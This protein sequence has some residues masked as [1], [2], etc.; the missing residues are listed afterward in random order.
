MCSEAKA[1]F[2]SRWPDRGLAGRRHPSCALPRSASLQPRP[3]LSHLAQAAAALQAGEADKALALL[4][5][6]PPSGPTRSPG[7]KSSLPRALSRW[8][9]STPPPAHANRQ[10]ASM[11]KTPTI[12]SGSAA[13]SAK[14]RHAPRS[15]PPLAW[16][17]APAPNSKKPFG[18]IR[19]TCRPSPLGEFYR[20]APGIVGGGVDKAQQIAAPTGQRSTPP[21]L[22]SFA[23]TSP[24]SKRTSPPPKASSSRQSPGRTPP[25]GGRPWPASTS[26]ASAIDD[27]E[28]A[29]HSVPPRALHDR[30]AAVALYDAAGQLIESNATPHWPQACLTTYLSSSSKTEEAPAFIAHLRLARLK[31]Q[32]G[33]P[34]AAAAGTRRRPGPGPRIQARPGLN[35]RPPDASPQQARY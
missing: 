6:P 30:H 8:S 18:S 3:R 12:T 20:Q 25:S 21:A 29:V 15:S 11:R 32:L 33:D 14:K 24:S 10:S 22:T 16:P 34:A 27:M 26:A 1:R 4:A 7:P 17:S 13:P 35:P 28:S 23:A 5:S 31:Q 9:N 2:W 19:T